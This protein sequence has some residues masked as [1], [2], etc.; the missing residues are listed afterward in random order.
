M[1]FITD[2]PPSTKSGA[3]TLLIITDRLIKGVILI[4]ILLISTP[5]VTTA[6]IK[7]YIP[8]HGFPKAII[9]NRGTQFTSAVWAIICEALGIE[10]RLSS[11]YHPET[12][13]ATERANQVIQPYLRAY[14]TFSQDN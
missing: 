4:P 5:A 9:N 14:T 11:A 7:H 2:L 12:N 10:R 13:G 1:D 8:Y 3:K 6:F